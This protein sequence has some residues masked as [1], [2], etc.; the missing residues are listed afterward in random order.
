LISL[1][2]YVKGSSPEVDLAIE[3]NGEINDFLR[4]EIKEKTPL[5]EVFSRMAELAGNPIK[6]ETADETVSVLA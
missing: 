1:G 5:K 4:Q 3:M 2:A 6:E